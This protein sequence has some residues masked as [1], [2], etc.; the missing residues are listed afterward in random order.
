MSSVGSI[1]YSGMRAAERRLEVAASNIANVRSGL[2]SGAPDEVVTAY[3]ALRA[4]Q[5]ETSGGGTSVN[6]SR[7]RK[8]VDLASE[9][10]E[11]MSAQHSF[12]ANTK[13][14]G[15]FGDM[16]KALIDMKV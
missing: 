16:Q 10:I 6:V 11:L 3:N 5:V 12:T 13:V 7:T 15:I 14:A 2:P 9:L 4:D 8:P 1:A